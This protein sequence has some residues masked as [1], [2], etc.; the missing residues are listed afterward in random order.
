MP[1]TD[2]VSD[3]VD[4]F[5]NL[6]QEIGDVHPD[7]LVAKATKRGRDDAHLRWYK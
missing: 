7:E 5:L 3:E 1:L 6:L 4:E 2:L